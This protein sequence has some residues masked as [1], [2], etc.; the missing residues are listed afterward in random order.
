MKVYK[1]LF[2]ALPLLAGCSSDG[3]E[4][5]DSGLSYMHADFVEAHTSDKGQ[6]DRVLTDDDAELSL[7]PNAYASWAT[8][9][10]TTYR[11]LLYYNKVGS[12]NT[13]QPIQIVHVVT[14]RYANTERTD[15]LRT[16]PI[17]FQSLWRSRNG[18]YLN[19]GFYI[20]TGTDEEGKIGS[21][22]VGLRRDSVVTAADGG[23]IVYVTLTHNQNNV[24]QYYSS[25][26]YLSLPLEGDDRQ[27]AFHV[28]I[29]TY[30]GRVEK[31]I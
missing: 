18:K 4:T 26:A 9:A 16:D 28:K 25:R 12:D 5:G 24:P 3:Y 1:L 7:S 13:V 2:L 6:F 15:T 31:V 22:T 10:D 17:T 30:A 21:Q 20:K 19:I 29:N 27:S 23:R 14:A 11:A 8:K